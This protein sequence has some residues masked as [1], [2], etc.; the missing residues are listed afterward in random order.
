MG[1]EA[2][3][4]PVEQAAGEVG[5]AQEDTDGGT[6]GGTEGVAEGVAASAEPQRP[7]KSRTDHLKGLRGRT[8]GS[9][10][11]DP[12]EKALEW[13][14][15][16][17]HKPNPKPP[18][19]QARQMLEAFRQN[20]LGGLVELER[21][22]RIFG[23][24]GP[25]KAWRAPRGTTAFPT[26]R[27]VKRIIVPMD[28]VEVTYVCPPEVHQQLPETY[29]VIEL[30]SSS[31][32]RQRVLLIESDALS[33]VEPGG[34][35]PEARL[36]IVPQQKPAK[37]RTVLMPAV[38]VQNLGQ[39]KL[40]LRSRDFELLFRVWSGMEQNQT[41]P[42]DFQLASVETK[43]DFSVELIF[44][45]CKFPAQRAREPIPECNKH[46]LKAQEGARQPH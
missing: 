46:I 42:D 16:N 7:K 29:T 43:S 11:R 12:N 15:R 20:P 24:L 38:D 17:W 39:K 4:Q 34:R 10:N 14:A 25:V 33:P 8:E 23:D 19:E 27:R 6:D 37:N 3:E 13:L 5:G 1:Q 45:S 9:R 40:T 36:H 30:F 18:S 32:S 28:A 26:M 44:A 22:R 21:R 35:I 31:D 2:L 41:I